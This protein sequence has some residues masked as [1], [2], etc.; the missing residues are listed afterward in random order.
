MKNVIQKIAKR[1]LTRQVLAGVF[2]G[3]V[4]LGLLFVLSPQA[5]FASPKELDLG[6]YKNTCSS[7]TDIACQ[8]GYILGWLIHIIQVALAYLIAM[9]ADGT[10]ILI[11]YGLKMLTFP[12]VQAGFSVC[13]GI[14]N[15][16]FVMSLI[17]IAFQ[18]ILGIHEGEAK[19][20]LSKVILAAIL[21][22]FSYLFAGLLLDASN[23]FTTFFT[24][25][26]TSDN[27]YI[28]LNPGLFQTI[29][30]SATSSNSPGFW[31]MIIS[32]LA[33]LAFTGIVLVIMIAVF[34]TTLVRNLY[35]ACLLMVMPLT[36]AMWVFPGLEEH[37]S[38]WWTNFMKWGVT[39]LPTMTFFMYLAITAAV[40]MQEMQKSGVAVMPPTDYPLFDAVMNI[41]IVGGIMVAGLKISQEA[42]GISASAAL[43]AAKKTAGYL[44]NNPLTKPVTQKISGAVSNKLT[45]MAGSKNFAARWAGKA[46]VLTGIAGGAATFAHGREHDLEESS[47]A[48][49]GNMSKEQLSKLALTTTS[50]AE[51]A[52]IM[53]ALSKQKGGVKELAKL[54]GGP[55]KLAELSDAYH[56]ETHKEASSLEG[57]KDA[58]KDNPFELAQSLGGDE[59]KKISAVTG[60][61]M[62]QGE[63]AVLYMRKNGIAKELGPEQVAKNPEL[64]AEIKNDPKFLAS[65]ESNA[66]IEAIK[67]LKLKLDPT[68]ATK[69]DID[70][71][72]AAVKAAKQ[73]I[74]DNG[75][76]ASAAL[77]NARDQAV[78]ALKAA[79]G[80]G[81]GRALRYLDQSIRNEP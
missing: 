26:V 62:T 24:K 55:A 53:M 49:Y 36:W 1:I 38:K 27:I 31:G 77:K 28:A 5:A 47:K 81:A 14:V 59:Y 61:P 30:A 10:I 42:G 22:N 34:A 63:A 19:K 72:Y 11:N 3:V 21:V 35:V 79:T 64:V 33:A 20:Q 58:I 67:E 50:S 17:I 73:A 74:A 46:A 29:S 71:K 6:D 7:W 70:A 40:Q 56:A 45:D 44:A 16:V 41:L 65:F 39:M 18:I 68:G 32:Q 78:A 52:K 66:S 15:L 57:V 80:T 4:V 75:G 60:L 2:L 48:R 76:V 69:A 25:T 51:K 43:G 8:A 9:L 54:T 23:V 13:L 12:A 37:H